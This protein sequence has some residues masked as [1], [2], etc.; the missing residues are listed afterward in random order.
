MLNK[1][2]TQLLYSVVVSCILLLSVHAAEPSSRHKQKLEHA[3]HWQTVLQQGRGQN[4]YWHAW[5]GDPQVNQYIQWAASQVLQQY[6]IRLHHVKLADTTEAVSRILAEKAAG[7][8]QRGGVDLIWIN[9]ENFASL[10]QQQ[11]LLP[12]WA[13]QLPNFALVNADANPQMRLDFGLPTL[14]MEAPWG[15]SRLVFYYNSRFVNQPPMTVAALLRFA[16]QHPG[17][18]TYPRPPDFL[19]V[20][21]LKQLL[22]VLNQQ[23]ER[24]YQPVTPTSFAQLSAP[25]WDYLSQLKP[26]LWRKGRHYPSTGNELM[27]L[28]SDEELQLAF[29]FAPASVPAAVQRFDLPPATRS[30][31]MQ[32]G[33]LSNVH[34]VAIPFNASHS[35]GAKLV[36][37][38]LLSPQAQWHKQQLSVWGDATVLDSTLLE[39]TTLPPELAEQW[40]QRQKQQPE[41]PAALQTTAESVALAEP[42]PSWSNAMADGWLQRFGVQP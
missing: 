20:S 18:F 12:D 37:N 16:Q 9:G 23:D 2:L 22:L 8:E 31:V 34:F 29:T 33:S 32:D 4:V 25:V 1:G 42:H 6:D 26:H 15:Q 35:S 14:G 40:Q 38:F 17:R 36:A 30:Y 10:Q 27:R 19:G 3:A 21:F 11:L 39:S 7:N 5:G 28:M 24:L 13:E 41:H